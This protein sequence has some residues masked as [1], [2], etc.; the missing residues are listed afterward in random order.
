MITTGTI[1]HPSLSAL[2]KSREVCD[3]QAIGQTGGWAIVVKH[4]QA[5]LALTA[6]RSHKVR[7]FKKLETLVIYLQ[8]LGIT[9]FDVNT[10]KYDASQLKTSSRPDRSVALKMAHQ[11]AAYDAY[12]S[13]AVQEAL[14]D[15]SEGVSH[16]EAK[17]SFAQKRAAL[18]KQAT[19]EC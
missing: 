14:D 18:L 17:K 1:N 13:S 5:A 12:F 2:V 10:E 15:P 19:G 7:L 3:A 8:G 6:T 9:H 4:D 16:E 11:S